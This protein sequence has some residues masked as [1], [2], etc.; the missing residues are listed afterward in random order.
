MKDEKRLSDKFSV[1]IFSSRELDV[2]ACVANGHS[3]KRAALILKISDRTV[4]AHIRNICG[5]IGASA[6]EQVIYFLD[7]NNALD[8]IRER[9]KNREA[10]SDSESTDDELEERDEKTSFLAFSGTKILGAAILICFARFGIY[11]AFFPKSESRTV[12]IDGTTVNNETYIDRKSV[13]N[14]IDDAFRKSFNVVALV[15]RGGAGKTTI[16]RRYLQEKGYDFAYE[17]NAETASSA[18]I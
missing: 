5:K 10:I 1:D 9:F 6:K 12:V 11:P 14:Q 2:L 3:Y 15:G 17:I 13:V 18:E 8:E 7:K 16:A 4:N